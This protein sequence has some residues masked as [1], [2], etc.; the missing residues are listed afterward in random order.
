M[1]SENS[2]AHQ[3]VRL[4]DAQEMY[5]QG[6]L[7]RQKDAAVIAQMALSTFIHR[8]A[9]RRSAEDYGKT[10]RLLTAEESILIWRCDL[11]LCPRELK[12]ILAKNVPSWINCVLNCASLS[13]KPAAFRM[14]WAMTRVEV[15]VMCLWGK[16]PVKRMCK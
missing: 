4:Q 9:G 5:Y 16:P 2:A 1:N 3:A 6:Q 8:M 15:S 12:G 14:R 11:L 10:R 7:G 13:F